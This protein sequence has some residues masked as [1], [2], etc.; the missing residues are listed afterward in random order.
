MNE[1][2]RVTVAALALLLVPASSVRA[3][4]A[5]YTFQLAVDP[6]VN[7]SDYFHI[8]LTEDLVGAKPRGNRYRSRTS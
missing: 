6:P 5:H 8:H 2:A 1:I 7:T 4:D 3:E